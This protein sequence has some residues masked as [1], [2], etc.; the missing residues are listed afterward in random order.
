MNPE[1]DLAAPYRAPSSNH[2]WYSGGGSSSYYS[3]EGH[4]TSSAPGLCGL[5]NLGNTCF[6]NSAL[7]VGEH[8]T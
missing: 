1:L 6:M 3:Y 4:R 5:G 8:I 2:Y 7:Q